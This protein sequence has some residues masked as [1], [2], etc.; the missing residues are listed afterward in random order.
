A[1]ETLP[2]VAIVGAVGD[3]QYPMRG[4]NKI[5]LDKFVKN[6]WVDAS[7]DLRFYGRMSRPLPQLLAYAD[8]P[9]LPSLGGSEERCTQFLENLG[10]GTKGT[11]WRTY[12][13][14]DGGEKK[15]LIG[16]LATHMAESVGGKYD[17]QNLVG[18]TYLFPRFKHIEELYDAGEFSTLLNACGRHDQP[19]IGMD[20]CLQRPG[21]IEKGRALLSAH[22]RALREGVEYAYKN[23]K[24]WGPFLLLDG[25]GAIDDGIIGVVA[26][27]V[28][29]GGRKKPIIALALD[30]KG[31]IKISARGTKKLV[32]SGLNLGLALKKACTQVGGQGGGHQIAAGA[33]VPVQKIDEFLKIF[34]KIIDEQVQN[35]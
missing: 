31:D 13:Q 3:M 25:R 19:Q 28:F 26:G 9:F 5:L 20:V 29:P 27:M 23:T 24:D 6:G 18:E 35:I 33:T 16:A 34:S 4:A 10:L 30:L 8:D 1:L 32:A 11:A 7:I 17:A 14:L 15:K 21:A 12:A 2:E 22:K